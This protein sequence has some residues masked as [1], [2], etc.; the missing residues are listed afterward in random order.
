MFN[1]KELQFGDIVTLRN[2][3]KGI[4]TGDKIVYKNTFFDYIK[5]FNEEFNNLRNNKDL[6]IMKIERFVLED[7][8]T[9]RYLLIPVYE[10]KEEI[11]TQGSKTCASVL[12]EIIIMTKV[13]ASPGR[14]RFGF[15]HI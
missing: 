7:N 9:Q 14:K 1:K 6:D 2:G 11:R 3:E 15:F 12:K 10:R 8:D 5:E 13:K 4:T